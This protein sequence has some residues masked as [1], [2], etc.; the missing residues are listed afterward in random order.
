MRHK[1]KQNQ[2]EVFC[3]IPARSKSKRIKDKNIQ[4]INGLELF[5]HTIKF[6][7]NFGNL[8]IC[9]STDSK[10]Y[11]NIAKK[12]IKV[13]SLRPKKL[14]SDHVKT[15]DVFKYELEKIEKQQ[16]KKFKYLLLLQPTVP[17]RKK[18]D[19]KKALKYIKEKNVDSVVS[20][21]S[22]EG[23]HPYRMK[24]INKTNFVLNFINEKKE[25][26][27]PIQK[28]PKIFLRSGAIYLIE[29]KAFYKYKNLLGT[30][31]KPI[32]VKDKYAINIDNYKDL[33]VAKNF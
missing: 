15:Y 3:L 17:F 30:K 26:M 32:I 25:N 1:S 22:V 28:L 12:Y 31:V 24:K 6:A 14:S 29:R 27:E 13:D 5:V 4:I 9:F 18:A 23:N 11:L 8:E 20:L 16:N 10:K 7:K 33:I 19:L 21:N 2:K